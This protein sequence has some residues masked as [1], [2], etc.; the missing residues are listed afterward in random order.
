MEA[1]RAVNPCT[2]LAAFGLVETNCWDGLF[3]GKFVAIHSRKPTAKPHGVGHSR[4]TWWVSAPNGKPS[5]L[6]SSTL[7][8]AQ[9]GASDMIDTTSPQ[10][11]PRPTA[12]IHTT[13]CALQLVPSCPLSS[14]A[15]FA[16]SCL[17]L[18]AQLCCDSST[19]S[20]RDSHRYKANAREEA[21][22]SSD[23]G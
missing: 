23:D 8:T 21:F 11:R 5:S 6:R 2:A 15:C 1:T 14:L 20:Y 22:D 3:L 19:L 13:H 9:G 17:L 10:S 16:C 18:P 12:V 7:S 4:P